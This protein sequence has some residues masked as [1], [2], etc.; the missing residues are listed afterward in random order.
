MD[1]GSV[2]KFTEFL[3]TSNTLY[4]QMFIKLFC[5]Y[6]IFT[7]D[8]KH[9]RH[10]GMNFIDNEEAIFGEKYKFIENIKEMWI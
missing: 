2:Y 4:K 1:T 5:K 9:S 7:I 10:T 3:H 8:T 6:L